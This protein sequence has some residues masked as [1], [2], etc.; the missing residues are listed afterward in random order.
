MVAHERTI[1]EIAD[2]GRRRLAR[3]PLA[4][5]RLRGDRHA[6]RGPLRRLLHRPLPARRG[7]RRRTASSRSRRSRRSPSRPDP[8]GTLG[9][10]YASPC[11]PRARAP[12]CRRSSTG[13]TARGSSRS[14][15]SPPTS[16]ARGRSSGPRRRASRDASS[17]A[18]P[19][20]TAR[21]ATPRSATG[22]SRRGVELVVLAGYMQLLS[23]AFIARFPNRI[24][25]VHPALL[26]ELPGTRRDR[27]GIPPRGAVQR[28]HGPLRR[29]RRRHRADHPAGSRSSS[30]TLGRSRPSR[31]ACTRSSTSCCRRRSS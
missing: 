18:P 13:S 9:C 12:T 10:R 2:R 14:L 20:R 31:S 26:A 29:R 24:V 4:G 16:R 15:P 11:S 3:L 1:D 25:N 8:D 28:R 30:H 6:A 19:T 27:P 23:P 7:E 17:S 21:R 5:G 22:S